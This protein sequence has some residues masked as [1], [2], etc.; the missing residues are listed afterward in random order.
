[1]NLMLLRAALRGLSAYRPLLDAPVLSGAAAFLDAAARRDGEAA[2]E[3]YNQL[4]YHLRAEGYP[5]L[6]SWL[7]DA[8]RYT[9]TP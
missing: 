1:M 6:G 9:E 5:G 2:L 3:A 8:L 4:F 7:W